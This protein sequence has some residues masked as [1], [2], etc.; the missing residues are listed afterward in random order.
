MNEQQRAL[1][2][3]KCRNLY[4]NYKNLDFIVV[5]ESYFTLSHSTAAGNDFYYS[6]NVSKTP[7]M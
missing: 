4:L 1:T 7:V 2:R 5:D 3:P 6:D